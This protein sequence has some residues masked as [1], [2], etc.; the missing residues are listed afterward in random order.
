MQI[1]Y[2]IVAAVMFVALTTP[3]NAAESVLVPQLDGPWWSATDNPDLGPLT[4]PKQQPVDFA[5]WQAADGTWQIWSC[6]RHT[7]APGKTRVLHGW[8]SSDL[9]NKNWRPLG[10]TWRADPRLGETAG[11]MQAPHVV[12][13]D[14]LYHMF[15]GDWQNICLAVSRDGKQFERRPLHGISGRFGEGPQANARDPMLLRVGD[16]WHCYFTAH[17]DRVGRVLCRTTT[18]FTSWSKPHTVRIGGKAGKNFWSHE[19]P[20]VVK[21]GGWFYLF[22][23]Q[24]YRGQPHTSVYRSRDPLDFGVDNDSKLVT[25]LPVAAPE[26]VLHNGEYYIAALKPGLDGIRIARLKWVEQAGQ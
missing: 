1:C 7:K 26:I 14:G 13:I 21:K 18:D 9:T 12:Q 17:P 3:T 10:V 22:T 8:M 4:G 25:T 5:I 19:C 2:P 15:Y 6:I 24:K 11:G 23:T 16:R 20:H